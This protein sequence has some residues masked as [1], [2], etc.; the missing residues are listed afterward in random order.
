MEKNIETQQS[1][2][3]IRPASPAGSRAGS[4][5]PPPSPVDSQTDTPRVYSTHITGPFRLG[6]MFSQ[7]NPNPNPSRESSPGAPEGD[8]R[9][10]RPMGSSEE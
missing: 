1:G 9:S 10:P 4:V 2:L 7:R 8:P 6:L 5:P 3:E